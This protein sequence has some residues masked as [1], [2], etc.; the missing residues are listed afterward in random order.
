LEPFEKIISST[1]NDLSSNTVIVFMKKINFTAYLLVIVLQFTACK[2]DDSS[3]QDYTP[4]PVTSVAGTQQ[5]SVGQS[6]TLTVSWPYSSGCDVMDKFNT[7]KTGTTYTITALG[8]YDKVICTQDVGIKTTEYIFS[9][10]AAG[11]YTLDFVN[12]DG[13]VVTHTILVQ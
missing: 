2:K 4:W 7:K 3:F 6:I 12:P 9:A 5:A 11:N 8:Y 10:S 1:G 13:S